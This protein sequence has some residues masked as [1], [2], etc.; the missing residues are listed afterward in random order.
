MIV[1][2]SAPTN[3]IIEAQPAS[4]HQLMLIVRNRVNT[5]ISSSIHAI[6]DIISCNALTAFC[7]FSF[8]GVFHMVGGITCMIR[9]VMPLQISMI[10][11]RIKSV[12]GEPYPSISPLIV[13]CVGISSGKVAIP[14]IAMIKHTSKST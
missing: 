8:D 11:G 1:T 12:P 3:R 14:T 13:K 10:I 6:M 9:L 5:L 2:V 4:F 7:G